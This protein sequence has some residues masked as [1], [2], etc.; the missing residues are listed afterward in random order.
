MTSRG[1]WRVQRAA[2]L[3]AATLFLVAVACGSGDDGDGGGM[4]AE[5]AGVWSYEV[6]NASGGGQTCD[7][8]NI[9]LAFIEEGDDFYEGTITAGGNGNVRCTSSS[10]TQVS[11]FAGTADLGDVAVEGLQ[12]R[13][14]IGSTAADWQS[15]GEFKGDGSTMGGVA[16]IYLVFS[17]E[18][19]ELIGEW[20]A[21][22][23]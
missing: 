9:T 17:G 20:E 23:Q 18:V 1:P 15:V 3:G 4:N 8:D 5:L 2:R 11:N 10:G 22:R 7:V 21:V 12:V 14:D 13:F 19:E 16:A 6:R